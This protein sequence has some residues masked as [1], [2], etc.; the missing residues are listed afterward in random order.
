MSTEIFLTLMLGLFISPSATHAGNTESYADDLDSDEKIARIEDVMKDVFKES[1][2]KMKANLVAGGREMVENLKSGS[3]LTPRDFDLAAKTFDRLLT[4]TGQ[5]TALVLAMI[6]EDRNTETFHAANLALIGKF[7]AL[8]KLKEQGQWTPQAEGEELAMLTMIGEALLVGGKGMNSEHLYLLYSTVSLHVSEMAQKTPAMSK[9]HRKS[10]MTRF[11]FI[12]LASY[13][14]LQQDHNGW[15]LDA[16]LRNNL[17][18]FDDDLKGGVSK[19]VMNSHFPIA[20]GEHFAPHVYADGDDFRPLL[21]DA[22]ALEKACNRLRMFS[23]VKLD[24]IAQLS[25]RLS[26]LKTPKAR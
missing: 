5:E 24:R 10:L 19:K 7:H 15:Q 21:L 6:F 16:I 20:E 3:S 17:A 26:T 2:M 1:L 23:R 4:A 22:T 18:Q 12:T 25:L 8:A 11:D 14:N 9:E 13:L